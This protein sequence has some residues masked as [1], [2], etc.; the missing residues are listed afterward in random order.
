[1]RE[2]YKTQNLTKTIDV[3][4]VASDKPTAELYFVNNVLINFSLENKYIGEIMCE[5]N[6]VSFIFKNKQYLVPY[7]NLRSINLI[8]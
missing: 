8:K 5:S 1:M 4:L 3:V 7:S 6:Y 2:K